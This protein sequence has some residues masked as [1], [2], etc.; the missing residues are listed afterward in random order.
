MKIRTKHSPSAA[1]VQMRGFWTRLKRGGVSTALVVLS[2]SALM[3]VLVTGPMASK[4]A[5]TVVLR[6]SPSAD[7]A[8]IEACVTQNLPDSAG[9]IDFSV[10][11]VDRT[12]VVTASRAEIRWRKDAEEL[13]QVVLRVS[14]PAKTAGTALLIIDRE[15]GQ[16]EFFLRLPELDK[17]RRV[18]SKRMRGPVL[19]TD[20]SYE[21]L[22]RMRDPLDR[23]AIELVGISEVESRATWL[24]ETLPKPEDGSEYARVLTHIDQDTCIPIRIELY[25]EDDRLRKRLQAPVDEIRTVGVSKLPHVFVMEDLRRETHTVIRIERFDSSEDLPATEFTKHALQNLAPA[26]VSR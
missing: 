13:S 10:E 5:D 12:G 3:T 26:A 11:A 17:V 1:P 18:R 8:A 6:P 16:P 9:V 25:G 4:A 19:G 15:S 14:E 22:D 23:K 24:L 7:L 2:F 20:F 21:D